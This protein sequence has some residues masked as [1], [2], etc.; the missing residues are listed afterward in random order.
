MAGLSASTQRLLLEAAA[1]CSDSDA[2]RSGASSMG[3]SSI[4]SSKISSGDTGSYSS[5]SAAV[6]AA[7]KAASTS[8]AGEQRHGMLSGRPAVI[9]ASVPVQ[10]RLPFNHFA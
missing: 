5:A 4:T 8:S 3:G 1:D 9:P 6:P 7:R 10:V 2:F